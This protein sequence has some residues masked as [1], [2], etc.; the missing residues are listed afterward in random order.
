MS[1]FCFFPF[2]W[3]FLPFLFFPFRARKETSS[4]RRPSREK[5]KKILTHRDLHP[6]PL[7]VGDPV[8]PPLGI[9]VEH[10][11]ELLPPRSALGA[12]GRR[13]LEHLAGA[14]VSGQWHREPS[15]RDVALPV[16]PQVRERARGG[17]ARVVERRAAPEHRDGRARHEVLPPEHLQERRLPG[18]VGAQEQA[19]RPGREGEVHV[20]DDGGHAGE[21]TAVWWRLA[22]FFFF[23]GGERKEEGARE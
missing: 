21:R 15:E 19:A 9:D 20:D 8:H 18:A 1:F 16:A 22:F 5:G 2:S 3:V 7:P 13:A 23:E 10:F 17:Q 14:E 11:D 6:P 12:G 4:E